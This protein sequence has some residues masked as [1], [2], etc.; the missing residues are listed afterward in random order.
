MPV[1]LAELKQ[2]HA[3]LEAALLALE[4]LTIDPVLDEPR[5]AAARVRL[6]RASAHRRKL[7]DLAAM[8]LLDTVRS[9]EADSLRALRERNAA[10]IQAS[11]QHIGAWGLRQIT[12]DWPGYCRASVQVRA[13]I[14]A[15][16]KADQDTLYPLLR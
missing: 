4:A 7:S 5:V 12:A 8:E 6:S 16:V 13:A 1:T 10:Q 14:R 2:A 15:L 3:E 9:A 11:S